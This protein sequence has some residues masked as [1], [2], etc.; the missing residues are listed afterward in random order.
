MNNKFYVTNSRK[1]TP[2]RGSVVIG[3]GYIQKCFLKTE[4]GRRRFNK[5]YSK[6][7]S[8]AVNLGATH[9][10]TSGDWWVNAP[11]DDPVYSICVFGRRKPVPKNTSR[12]K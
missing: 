8:T 11:P 3:T 2:R 10:E 4:S 9:I 12:I 6:I 1:I 7:I 5:E